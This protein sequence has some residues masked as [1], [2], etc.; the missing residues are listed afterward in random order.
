VTQLSRAVSASAAQG[1]V[2]HRRAVVR[3]RRAQGRGARVAAVCLAV[4]VLAAGCQG[5][6]PSEKATP[7]AA[8]GAE[9][10]SSG[11]DACPA[12]TG[13]P[14]RSGDALPNLTLPCMDGSGSEFVLDQPTGVPMVV[15]LWG[16]WCPPCGKELP[17]FQRLHTD[18]AG[19]V[20]V[21]GVVTEDSP[22]K[23]IA[24]AKELQLTF[25]NVYDRQ[26]RVRQA[27]GRNALPVTLFVDARGV[28]THT[29]NG[30]PVDDALLRALVEK[31]LRVVLV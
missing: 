2:A 27:L 7:K 30:E 4:A 31:H 22:E 24:A 29:Y 20:R 10:R 16:S 6:E 17:A 23:S 14:A 3:G 9:F 8:G 26:G 19:K 1:G 18:A 5:A 28:I 12:P 13:P 25:A 15:N 11:F 21:L